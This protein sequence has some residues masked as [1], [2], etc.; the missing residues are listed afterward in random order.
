MVMLMLLQQTRR[1]SSRSS[2]ASSSIVMAGQMH[3]RVRIQLLL[4]I[5]FLFF[6]SKLLSIKYL[7]IISLSFFDGLNEADSQ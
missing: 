1:R 4:F 3:D 5:A 6:Y 2:F 7:S